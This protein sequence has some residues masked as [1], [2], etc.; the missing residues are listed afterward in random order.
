MQEDMI[1]A[2]KPLANNTGRENPALG[3]RLSEL[4]SKIKQSHLSAQLS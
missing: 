4:I 1:Y 3:E 2:P